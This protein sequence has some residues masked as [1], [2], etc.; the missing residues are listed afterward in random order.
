MAVSRERADCALCGRVGVPVRPVHADDGVARL[1]CRNQFA[2]F[3]E[4]ALRLPSESGRGGAAVP[5]SG[6]R[7]TRLPGRT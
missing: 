5:V 1:V 6:R 2:C 3:T 4:M 7:W